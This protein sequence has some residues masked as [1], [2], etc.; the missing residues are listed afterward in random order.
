MVGICTSMLRD[1]LPVDDVGWYHVFYN[2]GGIDIAI[3][4]IV[5]CIRRG[6]YAT[7]DALCF[8]DKGNWA[9]NYG[10]KAPN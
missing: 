7:Q 5:S 2:G 10:F 3:A 1:R 6:G 9:G 8:F 4:A